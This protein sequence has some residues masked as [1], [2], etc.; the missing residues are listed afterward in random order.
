MRPQHEMRSL[1]GRSLVWLTWNMTT[2]FGGT[3]MRP[4]GLLGLLSDAV[5]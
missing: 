4:P 1:T 5:P 2:L 3:T